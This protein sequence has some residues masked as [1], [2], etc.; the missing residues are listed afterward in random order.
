MQARYFRGGL[1]SLM[2]LSGVASATVNTITVTTL[3][4]EDGTN[5][6]ACSL[7]EAV[8]AVN[9][10]QPYGGCP[11]G[12]RVDKN[13]IQLD[14]GTYS[15]TLAATSGE[16]SIT[17]DVSILGKDTV[18][19]DTINPLT[20]Q[21]PNRVRPLT[22]IDAGGAARVMSIY[23]GLSLKDMVLQ[24]GKAQ[25]GNG[26][27]VYVAGALS[28]DNVLIK[29]NSA[30]RV[31]GTGLAA[32]N[33]GAVFL[34][35]DGATLTAN[36]SVF[37]NNT[38]D[39]GGGAVAEICQNNVN[40]YANHQLA[41]TR[42]LMAGNTASGYSTFPGA[43][44]I[45][46][47]GN[48]I[49]S[50]NDVTLSANSSAVGAAAV[51][52][53][54][55]AGAPVVGSLSL[56]NVTAA[57]QQGAPVLRVS[58]LSSI[59]VNASL[60]AFNNAG[61]CAPS[62]VLPSVI[63]GDWNA[64]D[65]TGCQGLL[66]APAPASNNVYFAPTA[67]ATDLLPLG[68]HGGLIDGYLPVVGSPH[69]L[70][71][72]GP[73]ANCV[74]LTDQRQVPR[75][76]GSG[77][78]IGAMERMVLTANDDTADSTPKTNRLAVVDILLNDSFGESDSGPNTFG[79][80]AVVVD[81]LPSPSTATC[82]WHD[83]SDATY[84]NK[85][86]VDNG[87]VLTGTNPIICT[88]HAVDNNGNPSATATVTVNIKNQSPV[89]VNDNYIRATGVATFSFNPLDNDTDDG[90]GSY[91]TPPRWA[92]FPILITSQ[93]ELGKIVGAHQ[94]PCPDS[95]QAVPKTCL[96]PP[97]T[98]TPDNNLAPFTDNITY[99]VYDADGGISSNEA[100]I[101]I[102]TDAPNPDQGGTGGSMDEAGLLILALLGLRRAR[103]L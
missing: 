34:A 64:T 32:G 4:D 68:D 29:G 76:S 61:G 46:I 48:S 45:G 90:D 66:L 103:K 78:D 62:T 11:A 7:R 65:D 43:G 54:L 94:G 20:G 79:S 8:K 87:G 2:L 80:P 27:G 86:V 63:T 5:A 85:L 40:P 84:P 102:A 100:K 95:T 58:G 91:G 97:L 53:V 77:C 69:V 24:N 88:Y 18:Q 12:S 6:A 75:L 31:S 35:T 17:S 82:V 41:F 9:T 28:L 99:R 33:G 25:D 81:P 89:A 19:T 72:A 15:L 50:L 55:P 13:A 57:E 93:P 30:T 21:K 3:A 14:A 1:L 98:Y 70:D 52:Y 39:V 37:E 16:L 56:T 71:K 101:V 22:V 49:V 59:A 26:G 96:A 67:L 92:L 38:A 42:V 36:D 83:A 51:Y 10:K 73:F 74:G 47:C 23:G 60:I 44:A